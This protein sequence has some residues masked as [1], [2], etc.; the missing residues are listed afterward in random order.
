MTRQGE[1]TLNKATIMTKSK[2]RI[3]LALLMSMVA[4]VASAHDFEVDGIYYV[5]TSSAEH[6]VAV[7]YRGSDFY[8]YSDEYTG[9][10]TI[11]E[12]VTYNGMTYSVTTIGDYAFYCCS[13]LTSITIPNSVTSI[14]A[15]AF[16]F[17]YN[18]TSVTIPSSVTSIGE[19]AFQACSS[20]TDV[21]C[22]ATDVPATGFGV[23]YGVTITSATL[24]V[25]AESI[26]AYKTT[27]PWSEFGKIV[28]LTD[29]DLTGIDE[30][31]TDNGQTV[32]PEEIYDLNGRK[33][34]R[35]QKGINIVRMSDGSVRKVMVK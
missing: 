34:A 4:S 17:C 29:E 24:H 7:S 9:K 31:P 11:P 19:S 21:Y 30:L 6:T 33:L 2:L 28:P 32:M 25:P 1:K 3:L 18:L 20:L 26:E 15:A 23:F 16:G 13:G 27:Y 12:T 5:I 35:M 22:L 8:S 14:G 10:V